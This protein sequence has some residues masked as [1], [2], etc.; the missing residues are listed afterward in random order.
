MHGGRRIVTS[1]V[2]KYEEMWEVIQGPGKPKPQPQGGKE[3][4]KKKDLVGKAQAYEHD[5]SH[6]RALYY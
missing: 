6:N 3:K 2:K 1:Q 4:K 5:N